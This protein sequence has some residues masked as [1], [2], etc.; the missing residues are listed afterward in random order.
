MAAASDDEIDLGISLEKVATIVDQARAVQGDEEADLG[1]A[2]DDGGDDTDVAGPDDV[3]EDTLRAYI[4]EL[5]DDEQAA[6]IALCW[7]GRGDYDSGEWDDAV[8]LAS[9]RNDGRDAAEYL[10]GID[11][12]GDLLS[13]GVASFG[14][15]LEEIER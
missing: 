13:E 1:A 7:V 9:E 4:T 15:S 3:T 8:G 11:N 6:L 5:N 10:L 14:L 12:L 2:A